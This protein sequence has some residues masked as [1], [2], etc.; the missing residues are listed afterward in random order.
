MIM[1]DVMV[2]PACFTQAGLGTLRLPHIMVCL[3][4]L[5]LYIPVNNFS[6]MLG[7][8]TVF[9][10][11]TT[12]SSAGQPSAVGNMS[13]YRCVSDCIP[14]VTSSIPAQY[15]TFVEIDHK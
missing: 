10:G 7:G 15:H 11:L 1:L 3:F 5:I 9:L 13:G 8:F 2:S 4:V 12:T 6:F 14:G